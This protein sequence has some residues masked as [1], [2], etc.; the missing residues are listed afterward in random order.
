[1][2]LYMDKK[3]PKGTLLRTLTAKGYDDKALKR[4]E[5]ESAG[6]AHF[7]GQLANPCIYDMFT[8]SSSTTSISTAP[9]PT[10]QEL[11]QP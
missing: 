5:R 11:Q 1:M 9:T 8:I 7:L 2:H 4:P 3:N 6:T 10:T